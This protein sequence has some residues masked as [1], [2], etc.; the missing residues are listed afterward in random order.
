VLA[1]PGFCDY[2]TLKHAECE[3]EEEYYLPDRRFEVTEEGATSRG[4]Y[5][6]SNFEKKDGKV[7]APKECRWS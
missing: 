6:S 7:F 4:K 1:D 5:D 2:E 3:R